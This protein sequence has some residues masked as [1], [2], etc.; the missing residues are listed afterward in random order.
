MV[1]PSL[2]V[3]GDN[4]GNYVGDI[5][6][7]LSRP[8]L[9]E[10]KDVKRLEYLLRKGFVADATEPS[11]FALIL[12]GKKWGAFVGIR[13]RFLQTRRDRFLEN[14]RNRTLNLSKPDY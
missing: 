6:G 8:D 13:R 12:S 11:G 10:E 9:L 5:E 14:L 2:H 4:V 1:D 3:D 7:M